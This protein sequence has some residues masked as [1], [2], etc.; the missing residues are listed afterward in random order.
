[1]SRVVGNLLDLSRIEGGAL[2][3]DKAWY[4][5]AELVDDVAARVAKL[6]GDHPLAIEVAPELPLVSIDYVEIA[7]VL[8]NL[9]ENAIKHTPPG[10]PITLS[11]RQVPGAIELAVH[12]RGPGIPRR[13]QAR[14]F[15]KFF[16]AP[17]VAG[18]PGVGI[19]L[20]IAKGLVEAHG[21]RIG[22]T[23]EPRKGTTFWF[24]LP[25]P[26]DAAEPPTLPSAAARPVGAGSPARRQAA[27]EE[28]RD[29]RGAHPGRG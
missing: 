11:A 21:G 28:E 22:V 10:T 25:L 14:L 6:A 17:S 20:A 26:P 3:P 23:S 5:V 18:A 13:D 24:T 27:A 29:E 2:R 15:D 8:T 19:G 7:Q 12:D 1:L 16:R 9:L 4:D